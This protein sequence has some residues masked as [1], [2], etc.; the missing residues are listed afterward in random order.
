MHE[1]VA[2]HCLGHLW[3]FG[4]ISPQK[5]SWGRFCSVRVITSVHGV[6]SSGPEVFLLQLGHQC[7]HILPECPYLPLEI[8]LDLPELS[9]Q[10]P[11]GV[12]LNFFGRPWGLGCLLALHLLRQVLQRLYPHFQ[13]ANMVSSLQSPGF[14]FPVERPGLE[15]P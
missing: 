4:E 15:F 13:L 5:S 6:R 3:G 2:W 8:R 11:Y 7:V 14:S 10:M 12:W 9:C 1:L